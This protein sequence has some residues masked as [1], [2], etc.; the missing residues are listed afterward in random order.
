[1]RVALI[2]TLSQPGILWQ[3]MRAKM[4]ALSAQDWVATPFHARAHGAPCQV[5]RFIENPN[6][7]VMRSAVELRIIDCV[8][9]CVRLAIPQ[10]TE[11]QRIED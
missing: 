9:D 3:R 8:A 11:W 10:P 7:G 5:V 1:M 4:K 2:R 6:D